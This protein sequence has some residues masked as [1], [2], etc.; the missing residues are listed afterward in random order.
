MKR[1]QV[2]ENPQL[3][4]QG[5]NQFP[6]THFMYSKPE[7]MKIHFR[8]I[9]IVHFGEEFNEAFHFA[10]GRISRNLT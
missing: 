10:T 9:R 8:F 4:K 1:I 2:K 7:R 6:K 3:W 5:K